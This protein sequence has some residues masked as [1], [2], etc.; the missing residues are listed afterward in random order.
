MIKHVSSAPLSVVVLFL[1]TVGGAV[2]DASPTPVKEFAVRPDA[3]A[4]VAVGL[5]TRWS[6]RVGEPIRE[7]VP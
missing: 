2:V 5:R 7:Q 1:I 4:A 3:A 6:D